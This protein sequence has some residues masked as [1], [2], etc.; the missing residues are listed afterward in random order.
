MTRTREASKPIRTEAE[1]RKEKVKCSR[2]SRPEGTRP[3]HI[4]VPGE[5]LG[6]IVVPHEQRAGRRSET[7]KKRPKVPI[8]PS[9]LTQEPLVLREEKLGGRSEALTQTEVA[10]SDCLP[11]E[12]RS[13]STTQPNRAHSREA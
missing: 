10:F 5:R 13:P 4:L 6:R 7:T 8:I 3:I 2:G 9:D 1:E 11:D 12:A